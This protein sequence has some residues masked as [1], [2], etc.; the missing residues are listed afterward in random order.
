MHWMRNSTISFSWKCWAATTLASY[1]LQEV[2]LIRN[3]TA[4]ADWPQVITMSVLFVVPFLGVAATV[5]FLVCSIFGCASRLFFMPT[6]TRRLYATHTYRRERLL[7][8]VILST[9]TASTICLR[10]QNFLVNYVHG[11]LP[12]PILWMFL[13]IVIGIVIL[14]VIS[15]C[16]QRRGC[17]GGEYTRGSRGRVPR[18]LMG[19]NGKG[20][21]YEVGLSGASPHSSNQSQEA[22]GIG[23]GTA[24]DSD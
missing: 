11:Y 19:R 13:F 4:Q 6:M 9:L 20:H 2:W 15:A 24:A 16:D 21:T 1:S 5:G 12:M 14:L 7:I 10:W 22:S 17:K 23:N 8:A 3:W 18:K